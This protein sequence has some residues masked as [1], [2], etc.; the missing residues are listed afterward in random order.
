MDG[1]CELLRNT[2][3]PGIIYN[4]KIDGFKTFEIYA[5]E[6]LAKL[7]NRRIS[8]HD[9]VSWLN[10][11]DVIH[12]S[13]CDIV[14]MILVRRQANSTCQPWESEIS[15][16][17]IDLILEYFDL[18]KSNQLIADGSII[19]LP[20]EDRHGSNK[21][22]SILAL[23]GHTGV[24]TWTY[25]LMTARTDVLW[26]GNDPLFPFSV[27]G[28]VLESQKNLARH[29]MFMA[30]VAA[31]CISQATQSMI[32]P[33]CEKINQVENRTQ[34]SP[35]NLLRGNIAEGNY[36][37]LSAMMSGCATRLAAFKGRMQNLDDIF[38]SISDYRWPQRI[39]RPGWAETVDNE[40]D[41]CVSI[42]KQLKKGQEQRICYLSQRADIQLTAVSYFSDSYLTSKC[43]KWETVRC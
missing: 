16:K 26:Y 18:K 31:L 10:R 11:S 5:Q 20:L 14:R 27:V 19:Y 39:Q 24:L 40:L 32:E 28:P 42:L 9:V 15:K 33:I 1:L 22:H 38:Q 36:A 8:D 34:H 12:G 17:N 30:L 37:A 13:K 21:Q 7:R 23:F 35:A 41:E 6:G 29:P 25:D 43:P 2:D 3:R 4:E